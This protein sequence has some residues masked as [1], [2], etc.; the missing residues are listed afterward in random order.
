[1]ASLGVWYSGFGRRVGLNVAADGVTFDLENHY[2]S[3]L[4]PSKASQL[5]NYDV[6]RAWV[7]YAALTATRMASRGARRA[8]QSQN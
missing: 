6:L 2:R 3:W 1:M 8:P 5:C 4:L 7:W